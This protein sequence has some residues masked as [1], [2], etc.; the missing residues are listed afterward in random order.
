MR[1]LWGTIQTYVG[2]TFMRFPLLSSTR[3]Q[4]RKGYRNGKKQNPDL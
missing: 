4:S 2:S 3:Y 1:N